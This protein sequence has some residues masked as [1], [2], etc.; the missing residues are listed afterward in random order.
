M[1]GMKRIMVKGVITVRIVC[2]VRL[3]SAELRRNNILV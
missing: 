3:K 2:P 1:W